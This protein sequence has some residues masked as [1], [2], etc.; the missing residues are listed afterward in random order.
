[1]TIQSAK[2]TYWAA[3]SYSSNSEFQ[4]QNGSKFLAGLVLKGN[5]SILDVGCGH[6][7]ITRELAQR[8]PQGQVVGIDY[9]AD[10]IAYAKVHNAGSNLN[11]YQM[12]AMEINVPGQTFDVIVST[13]CLQWTTDKLK[14]FKAMAAHLKPGGSVFLLMSQT[15]REL[16]QIR[17]EL[18]NSEQ[19]RSSFPVN[20]RDP[21]QVASI[22][23]Y[24]E[25]A[26]AV[27]FVS[28]VH[29]V[30]EAMAEFQ[31]VA[32][33]KRFLLNVTACLAELSNPGL[34]EQFMDELI[35]RYLKIVPADQ[36]GRCKIIFTVVKLTAK[37]A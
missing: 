16:G 36:E 4:Y 12:D 1:M 22:S 11:Y 7:R 3:A 8:V 21:Q 33:L 28:V 20:Y 34:R 13:F 25:Y 29:A 24:E 19:W 30:E 10:M 23:S 14:A 6:G 31:D 15:N 18:L 32:D 9:S 5:E 35:A 37:S 2:S 26:E 17:K 27:G